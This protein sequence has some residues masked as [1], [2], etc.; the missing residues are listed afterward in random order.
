MTAST[1]TLSHAQHYLNQRLLAQHCIVDT[2]LEDIWKEYGEEE[3][4]SL[5]D[6][7]TS[8]NQQLGVLG[9]EIVAVVM[10]SGGE[11]QTYYALINK[12]PD[13]VIK[14]GFKSL[15]QSPAQHS[16]A[17]LVLQELATTEDGSMT[18][19]SLNNLRLEVTS[20]SDLSQDTS[21]TQTLS[22]KLS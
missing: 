18:R 4:Q 9:L 12:V 14:A 2:D 13:E 5:Q 22:L 8:C 6:A 3:N 20:A 7:L 21:A 19:N 10:K 16:Y 11:S 15:Q 17:R 1:T